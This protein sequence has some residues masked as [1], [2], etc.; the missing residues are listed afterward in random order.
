MVGDLHIHTIYS[1][2]EYNEFEIV[3]K[4]IEANVKEFAICD[5]DTIDGS[6]KVN[7]VLK[8]GNYDLIF[9]TGVELTVRIHNFINDINIHLLYRDFDYNDPNLA[10]ALNL[11]NECQKDRISKMKD[12]IKEEFNVVISDEDVNEVLSKTKSFGKPHMYMILSKYID[13]DMDYYYSKMKQLKTNKADAI[14]I[15]NILKDSLGYLTLAHPIEIMEENN[16]DYEFVDKVVGYLSEHGLKGLETR[17]SK[18]ND[19]NYLMFSKIAKK[20]KLIE[21]SGSDFH[22]EHVKP[23]VKIGIYKKN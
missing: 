7:D 6:K 5:H 10:K 1:D 9:H 8:K 22:G 15:M 14:E 4:I 18:H 23:D 12:I 3:D 17:H 11:I 2:G 20:Y 16:V 19:E 13:C 21:T